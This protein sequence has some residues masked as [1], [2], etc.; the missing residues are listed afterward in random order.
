M[1]IYIIYI[2]EMLI[3]TVYTSIYVYVLH[4]CGHL[5]YT[6][7]NNIYTYVHSMYVVY[8]YIVRYR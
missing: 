5:S 3:L 2:I 8:I 7:I 1:H 4:I 6:Y